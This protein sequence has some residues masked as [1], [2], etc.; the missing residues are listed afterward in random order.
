MKVRVRGGVVLCCVVCERAVA[1]V[2]YLAGWC[3]FRVFLRALLLPRSFPFLLLRVGLV[4]PDDERTDSEMR[5]YVCV[6]VACPRSL[7]SIVGC[8]ILS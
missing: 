7:S 5:L 1:L 2:G 3:L 4:L 8:I 6:Q